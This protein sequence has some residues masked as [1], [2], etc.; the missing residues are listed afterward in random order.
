[1]S[2]YMQWSRGLWY[3]ILRGLQCR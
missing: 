3:N 2:A 1:L